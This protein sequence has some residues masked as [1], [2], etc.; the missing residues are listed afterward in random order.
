MDKVFRM[1]G[2]IEGF[3]CNFCRRNLLSSYTGMAAGKVVGDE[4]YCY[5]CYPKAVDVYLADKRLEE[6][7]E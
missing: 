3:F 4:L 6:S 2:S 1:A 7:G 5:D